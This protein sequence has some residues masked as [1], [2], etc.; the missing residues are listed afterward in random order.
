MLLIDWIIPSLTVIETCIFLIRLSP[1]ETSQKLSTCPWSTISSIFISRTWLC[2]C[3]RFLFC[4][5]ISFLFAPTCCWT[6]PTCSWTLG[7][8][9]L[10]DWDL[11]LLTI[12]WP[13]CSSCDNCWSTEEI[14]LLNS[15]S[16]SSFQVG[17]TT[18]SYTHLTLPTKRIV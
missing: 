17:V 5:S 18:V 16:A 15:F 7:S 9:G 11:I 10:T 8:N 1:T 6:W 14:A 13:S 2:C 3:N 4:S 12:C